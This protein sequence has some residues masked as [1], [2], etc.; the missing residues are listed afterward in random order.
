M[1]MQYHRGFTNTL[2]TV[3][4]I[5]LFLIIG[6]LGYNLWRESRNKPG[7]LPSDVSTVAA[8]STPTPTLMGIAPTLTLSPTPTIGIADELRRLFAKKY[9]HPVAD[10][11]VTISKQDGMHVSGGIKF[12]G[13]MAGGW[14]LAAKS[15]G[16]W[17]IV[18]DGNGT[19]DCA[20]IAPYNFSSDM[21]P[22]CWDEKTQKLIKR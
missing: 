1:F 4:I 10:A 19:I 2:L 12:Q 22:E 16:A 13:E 18:Q 11:I 8:T 7:S 6:M 9:N 5:L 15:G 20:T 14:F 17:V 21:V 3:I